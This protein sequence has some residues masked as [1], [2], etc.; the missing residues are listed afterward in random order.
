MVL[1]ALFKLETKF[2]NS[3]IQFLKQNMLQIA[4]SKQ[5]CCAIQKIIEEPD[6]P[7]KNQLINKIVKLS[8][9][10]VNDSQGHYVINCVVSIKNDKINYQIL[11]K[12]MEENQIVLLC[13]LKY[14]AY[15]LEKLLDCSSLRIRSKLIESILKSKEVLIDVILNVNGISSKLNI[16]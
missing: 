16:L 15:V 4:V 11:T 5:G 13:K 9:K 10:L 12:L 14:P 2:I 7:F 8:S 1:K 3:I 6:I